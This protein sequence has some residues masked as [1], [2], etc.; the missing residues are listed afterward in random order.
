MED[1]RELLEE[2]LKDIVEDKKTD[3][4]LF[5][6]EMR[7]DGDSIWITGAKSALFK[8]VEKD[9]SDIDKEKVEVQI[10]RLRDELIA[11]QEL[12]VGLVENLE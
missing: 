5:K 1:I 9:L 11:L 8:D 3:F 12:V 4:G 6:F 2:A 10:G 7:T